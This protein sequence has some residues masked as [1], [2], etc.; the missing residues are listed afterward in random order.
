M[1][2]GNAERQAWWDDFWRDHGAVGIEGGTEHWHNVVWGYTTSR[3]HALFEARSPGRRL[4]ECGCGAARVSAYMANHGYD[5]TLIDY[6]AQALALARARFS[7]A[8][9]PVT[10]LCSDIRALALPRN[11]FDIVYSGGVLEFFSDIRQPIAEMAR[12]LKPGGTLVA[13]MVPPKFSIQTVADLE[14]TLAYSARRLVRGEFRDVLK[15]TRMV[16]PEYGVH[17]W[18][19]SDYVDACAAAGLE[20]EGRVISPFPALAL[21]RAGQRMYARLMRA[22]EAWWRRFDESS[23]PWTKAWGISYLLH[24]TK[25]KGYE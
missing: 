24:A 20:A 13:M 25:P 23:A 21:P 4:L 15:R 1:T 2:A 3:L 14:R 19:L 7:A 16:P 8:A 9:L 11:G 12:V 22:T 17:P 6:S 18:T 10:I 5:C